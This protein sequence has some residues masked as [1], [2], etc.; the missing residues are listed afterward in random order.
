MTTRR[1]RERRRVARTA[2][3]VSHSL[4]WGEKVAL[5]RCIDSSLYVTRFDT[6]LPIVPAPTA[7]QAMREERP[8]DRIQTQQER[9]LVH[10]AHLGKGVMKKK[11]EK[12]QRALIHEPL[13]PRVVSR[14]VV[15][16]AVPEA[17]EEAP[18]I[19]LK[20]RLL[21]GAFGILLCNAGDPDA[22][23]ANAGDGSATRLVV[24]RALLQLTSFLKPVHFA[25]RSQR[26]LATPELTSD[27]TPPRGRVR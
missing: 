21:T 8:T 7:V 26:A 17:S 23:L 6:A 25:W 22:T 18:P 3:G 19:A 10:Q 2:T 27:P 15:P 24:L 1:G 14:R 11:K 9:K 20:P 5:T 13:R 12:L 4:D 16:S